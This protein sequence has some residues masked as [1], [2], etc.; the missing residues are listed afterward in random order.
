MTGAKTALALGLLA[1][2]ASTALPAAAADATVD[3]VPD[4]PPAPDALPP[5]HAGAIAYAFGYAGQVLEWTGTEGGQAGAQAFGAAGCTLANAFANCAYVI[6]VD[7]TDATHY[8]S[9]SK[10][11]EDTGLWREANGCEGLQRD[12]VDCRGGPAAEPA[13]ERVL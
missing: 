6:V 9:A 4:P 2:A 13:D 8:V 7:E 3:P 10:A 12:A 5:A 1:L 11:P